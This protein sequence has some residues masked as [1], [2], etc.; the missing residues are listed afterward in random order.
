[1]SIAFSKTDVTLDRLDQFSQRTVQL[2]VN[3]FI[4]FCP[5]R[6]GKYESEKTDRID[7]R[8]KATLASNFSKANPISSICESI[9][10][11]VLLAEKINAVNSESYRIARRDF[12]A[13]RLD[14]VLRWRFLHD[15]QLWLIAFVALFIAMRWW[16]PW[17]FTHLRWRNAPAYT[18]RPETIS[19]QVTCAP[20]LPS[21]D[22]RKGHRACFRRKLLVALGRFIS[23]ETQLIASFADSFDST[24]CKHRQIPVGYG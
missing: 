20:C 7:R 5:W 22:T 2:S 11:I 19:F 13:N 9:R 14:R 6:N 12:M 16:I 21:I 8:V 23:P 15:H 18:I 3:Y 17:R 4:I 24:N 1:M 10:S